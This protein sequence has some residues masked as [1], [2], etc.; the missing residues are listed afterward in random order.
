[1]SGNGGAVSIE[2]MQDLL[3][4][5][6]TKQLLANYISSG[7]SLD[8]TVGDAFR[9]EL[10][11]IGYPQLTRNIALS[12]GNHCAIPQNFNPGDNLFSLTGYAQTK[13]LVDLFL[14]LHPYWNAATAITLAVMFDEPGLL[15]GVLPG[16]S[17]FNI[18]FIGKSLPTSGLNSEIYEGR[19]TFT[20]TLVLKISLYECANSK[21]SLNEGLKNGF[22]SE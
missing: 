4:A 15:I 1:M 17:K 2:D 22:P 14:F 8:N 20:K 13:L 6:G 19:I 12:N 10:R 3:E 7:F 5:P 9:T 11:N 21:L 16:N 18:N